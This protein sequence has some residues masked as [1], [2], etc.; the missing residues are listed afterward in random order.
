MLETGFLK[1]GEKLTGERPD[2]RSLCCFHK[3]IRGV[4]SE[5]IIVSK[6]DMERHA[7]F[8]RES[9]CQSLFFFWRSIGCH[10]FE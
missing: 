8:E 7:S 5:T 6:R 9:H 3:S 1:E 10:S 4:R 2:R